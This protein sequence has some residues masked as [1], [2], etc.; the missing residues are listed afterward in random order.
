[1]TDETEGSVTATEPEITPPSERKRGGAPIR[2]FSPEGEA[3]RQAQRERRARESANAGAT[4]GAS[5]GPE[6]RRA[7]KDEPPKRR[8]S[9]KSMSPEEMRAYVARQIRGGHDV[10]AMFTG[11]DS[12]RIGDKEADSI[13]E[14]LLD[15]LDWMGIPLTG[16]LWPPVQLA[17]ALALVYVPKLAD[18][19]A[20]LR[21]KA[22]KQAEA[23]IVPNDNGPQPNGTAPM[24]G[25]NYDF[26]NHAV[27]APVGPS[28]PVQ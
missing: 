15:T 24:Q 28:S 22:A 14:P 5:S 26:G 18:I 23:E 20:E 19:D 3:R 4:G 11:I 6:R 27:F 1:M 8:S 10:A 21:A 13:A 16:K 9:R 12:L 25:A 2:D 7:P 17:V